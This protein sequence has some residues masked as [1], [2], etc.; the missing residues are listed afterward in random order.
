[1]Q[2]CDCKT[3]GCRPEDNEGSY[4]ALTLLEIPVGYFA[5]PTTEPQQVSEGA[6]P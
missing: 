3:G 6:K 5:E 4:C 1:M 2:V